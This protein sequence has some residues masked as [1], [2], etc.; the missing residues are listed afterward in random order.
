MEYWKDGIVG[1][2]PFQ[3]GRSPYLDYYE[4]YRP[5]VPY[6]VAGMDSFFSVRLGGRGHDRP[7]NYLAPGARLRR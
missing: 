2:P 7:G 3:Q 1:I 6:A 5:T 4:S